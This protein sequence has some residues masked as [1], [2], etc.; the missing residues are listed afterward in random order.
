MGGRGGNN[1]AMRA[2][3]KELGSTDRFAWLKDVPKDRLN[4]Y[5]ARANNLAGQADPEGRHIHVV[6]Y[7]AEKFLNGGS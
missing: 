7:Y 5:V 1:G 6:G 3:H 2:E 4:R